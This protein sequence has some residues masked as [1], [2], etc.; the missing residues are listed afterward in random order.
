MLRGIFFFFCFFM[1]TSSVSYSFHSQD[2]QEYLNYF[3]K[4]YKQFED[5]YYLPPDRKVY[6]DFLKKFRTK[7]YAQLKQE[8]KSN[9]Y[10]RWRAAWILVDRLKS[11]EDR[12]TQFYPPKPAVKFQHEALGQRVDLGI[13]GKK[14]DAGFLVTA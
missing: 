7:I 11:K 9:N 3:E 4:V 14:T 8:K 2:Y 1:I 13:A 6:N 10:V 5:H 12:F